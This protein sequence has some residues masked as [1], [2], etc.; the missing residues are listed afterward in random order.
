[1][2]N[3]SFSYAS[4][5][6]FMHHWKLSHASYKCLKPGCKEILSHLSIKHHYNH[7]VMEEARELNRSIMKTHIFSQY[8][9]SNEDEYIAK[10]KKRLNLKTVSNNRI[11]R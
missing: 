5:S 9:V 1:M 2:T 11:P 7:H 10:M 8:D 3:C 4:E 6:S